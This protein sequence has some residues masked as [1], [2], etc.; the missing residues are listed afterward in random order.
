M[1]S[2]LVARM[3][4]ANSAIRETLR[5]N[6][7]SLVVLERVVLAKQGITL[8]SG[9]HL[10]KGTWL[11]V[12]TVGPQLDEA[13][14]PNSR[15]YQPFRFCN[16]QPGEIKEGP[17]TTNSI[18]NITETFLPFGLGKWAWYV[19]NSLRGSSLNIAAC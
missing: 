14:Y 10:S 8:P 5:L 1:D 11:G 16:R 2:N 9:Q 6:P 18:S 19:N 3:P 15:T 12:P 7:F 13:I 17:I 4:F